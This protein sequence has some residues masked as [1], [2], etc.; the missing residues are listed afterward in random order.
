MVR[1]EERFIAA[2]LRPLVAVCGRALVGDTGSTDATVELA[3]RIPGVEIVQYGECGN[4]ALTATRQDLS[5]RVRH[6]G[7][8]WQLLCDGDELYS[9]ATLQSIVAQPSPPATGTGFI[10]MLSLDEDETTGAI[11][12]LDDVFSRQAILPVPTIYGGVYPFDA[13]DS[14][15]RPAGFY[16]Y[17]LPEGFRWHALH[18]HRLWRSAHD[19]EVTLRTLKRQ[20]FSMQDKMVP[21]TERFDLA[22]WCQ[23]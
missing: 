15:G 23:L 16:Y 1:N 12:A 9:V 10:G 7:A 2:V 21:R 11:W 5:D 14:F 6:A 22:T 19:Q 20:Q 4:A 13:P 8:A 17:Q 18:L 3:A